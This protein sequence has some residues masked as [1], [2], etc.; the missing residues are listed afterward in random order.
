MRRA[1]AIQVAVNKGE[2]G[3]SVKQKLPSAGIT[4]QFRVAAIAN[5]GL[6]DDA[7]IQVA[8]FINPERFGKGSAATVYVAYHQFNPVFPGGCKRIREH[9][10]R[11]RGLSVYFPAQGVAANLGGLKRSGR[12]DHDKIR[13]LDLS[14]YIR[15]AGWQTAFAGK[16]ASP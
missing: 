12:T 8:V 3:L 10:S 14:I 16:Q 5:S 4:H 1:F 15:G 11:S 7:G 6:V 13:H 9:I 2:D